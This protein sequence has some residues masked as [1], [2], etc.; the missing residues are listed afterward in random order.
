M[1]EPTVGSKRRYHSTRV[2]VDVARRE[3]CRFLQ[4]D[5]GCLCIDVAKT[6]KSSFRQ[7]GTAFSGELPQAKAVL[8]FVNY[9]GQTIPRSYKSFDS[10]TK[11]IPSLHVIS[12][13]V[14]DRH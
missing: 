2:C 9:A 3:S 4:E 1:F 14:R 6:S 13:T 10:S 12:L 5:V 11:E 8:L 7:V